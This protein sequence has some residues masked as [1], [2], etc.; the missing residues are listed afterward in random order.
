[1]KLQ[2]EHEQRQLTGLVCD[3]YGKEG[4]PGIDSSAL[5]AAILT[6]SPLSFQLSAMLPEQKSE[7]KPPNFGLLKRERMPKASIFPQPMGSKFPVTKPVATSPR[8]CKC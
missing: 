7:P 5:L 6:S 4:G 1:M 3:S 2:G 8:A